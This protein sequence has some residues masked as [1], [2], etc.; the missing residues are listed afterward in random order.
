MNTKTL[1]TALIKAQ[2]ELKDV[3]KDG[4]NDFHKYKYATLQSY[5]HAIRPVLI[6][7]G[8]SIVTSVEEVKE[9]QE[10]RMLVKMKVSLFHSSGESIDTFVYG[11]GQ[12]M[13][14]KGKVGDKALYKAITGGRKYALANLF[15]IATTDDPEKDETTHKDKAR[16]VADMSK[17][18][19]LEHSEHLFVEE[20]NHEIK[21]IKTRKYDIW[22]VNFS[23]GNV[24]STTKKDV[25]DDCQKFL[26]N[27]EEVMI[28]WQKTEWGLGLLSI[29]E[30]PLF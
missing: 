18:S 22:T 25:A 12:D 29:C 21:E 4:T 30:Q 8:L 10:G 20:I 16:P 3:S 13:S 23:D 26:T 1:I 6:E 27:G 2:S 14:A 17:A 7:N 9:M 15:N 19:P 24:Y 28:G 5:L 11:E